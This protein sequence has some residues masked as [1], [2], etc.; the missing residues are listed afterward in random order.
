[1]L[2]E[3]KEQNKRKAISVSLN[4][5]SSRL[6]RPKSGQ[7]RIIPTRDRRQSA[8]LYAR[9]SR[10]DDDRGSSI[11]RTEV[12]LRLRVHLEQPPDERPR[13]PRRFVSNRLEN[14]LDRGHI[15]HLASLRDITASKME[16]LRVEASQLVD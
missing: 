9:Y 8:D 4:D 5:E 2:L 1:M 10:S 11:E 13:R 7:I 3:L 12:G 6:T 15:A 16:R 14:Y